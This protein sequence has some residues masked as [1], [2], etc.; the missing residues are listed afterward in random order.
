MKEAEYCGI[1]NEILI[2]KECINDSCNETIPFSAATCPHCGANQVPV[3][4][5]PWTCRVCFTKNVSTDDICTNC[6]KVRGTNH[7]LSEEELLKNS[8][9]VD[10]LSSDGFSIKLSDDS[11]SN[12][13]KISVYCTHKPIIAPSTDV[14]HPLIV[15]KEI[16]SLK[17]FVDFSHPYFTKCGLSKE[18]LIAS[19]AALYLYQERMNLASHA[20]HNLSNLTWAVLETNWKGEVEINFEIIYLEVEEVL[21]EIQTRIMDNLGADASLY[22]DELN[23]NQKKQLTDTLIQHGID[24]SSITS[25][26]ENGKYL[27]HVPYSF[28]LTLFDEE[29]DMFFGGKVWSQSLAIGGEDLLGQENVAQARIKIINQYENYLQ[30]IINFNENKYTDLLTI[31]RVRLSS[32]FLRRGLSI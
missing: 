28:F 12:K 18:Q 6:R 17:I 29:P 2:K 15:F 31:Q 13:V 22:F 19:E 10:T 8:D 4:L 21:K 27:L 14:S 24:L 11:Y 16:G 1:C 20:E 9:K 23:N 5:E 25:L 32:E 7:P 3:I 30:D 26:R